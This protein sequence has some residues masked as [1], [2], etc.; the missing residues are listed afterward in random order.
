[1]ALLKELPEEEIPAGVVLIKPRSGRTGLN[2]ERG[3]WV[4]MLWKRAMRAFPGIKGHRSSWDT[5]VFFIP[6]APLDEVN[7]TFS[8]ILKELT[9]SAL[10]SVCL[11]SNI[12]GTE[13]DLF[14]QVERMNLQLEKLDYWKKHVYPSYLE[15]GEE[16]SLDTT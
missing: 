13:Q 14:R 6:G 4:K 11:F 5:L 8:L 16:V 3:E 2:E 9:D 15:D 7:A 1:M 12:R 10:K